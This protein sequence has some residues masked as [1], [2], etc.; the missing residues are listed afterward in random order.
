MLPHTPQSTAQD[1]VSVV[2]SDQWLDEFCEQVGSLCAVMQALSRIQG[3]DRPHT[4]VAEALDNCGALQ[5]LLN[6]IPVWGGYVAATPR[7][8]HA[9]YLSDTLLGDERQSL[10]DSDSEYAAIEETSLPVLDPSW[11]TEWGSES[12]EQIIRRVQ[13]FQERADGDVRQLELLSIG[14]DWP[15][16]SRL[17][18]VLKTSAGH[19]SAARIVVDAAA[20]QGAARAAC[21]GDVELALDALKTDLRAC[22]AQVEEWLSTGVIA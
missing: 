8:S 21:R 3:N 13:N 22:A 19:V 15:R 7:D 1:S 12:T 11:L 18:G 9:A 20:L 6:V 10:G 2:V 14:S 16:L 4:L 5:D 17:A